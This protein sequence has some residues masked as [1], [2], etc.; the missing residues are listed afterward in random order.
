[1]GLYDT[2]YSRIKCP[3]CRKER[4]MN[5]QTKDL[6]NSCYTFVAMHSRYLPNM[7]GD[8]SETDLNIKKMAE[9]LPFLHANPGDKEYRVWNSFLDKY[10]ADA[11]V[12]NDFEDVEGVSAIAECESHYCMARAEGE[13]IEKRGYFTGVGMCFE[14]W[15]PVWQGYLVEDRL[16]IG[17]RYYI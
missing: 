16:Q 3:Y 5:C 4:T 15:I 10:Q 17:E 9:S 14:V 8:L 7:P 2:I 1:M 13:Q 12:G 11:W 6:Y